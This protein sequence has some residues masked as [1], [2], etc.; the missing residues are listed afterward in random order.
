MLEVND[1]YMIDDMYGVYILLDDIWYLIN[2]YGEVIEEVT[3]H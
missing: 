3:L 1:T 2:D